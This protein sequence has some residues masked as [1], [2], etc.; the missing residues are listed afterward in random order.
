MA[1]KLRPKAAGKSILSNKA[2]EFLRN[3]INSASPVGFETWGQK[4]WLEYL[5][6]YVDTSYVDPYGTAVGISPDHNLKS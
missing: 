3:Y 2:M 4:L 5:K 1:K 6:P